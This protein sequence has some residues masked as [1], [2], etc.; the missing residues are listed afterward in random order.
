MLEGINYLD[1]SYQRVLDNLW[2]YLQ[3]GHPI[4]KEKG[5]LFETAFMYI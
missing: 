4:K 2:R 5:N 3:E 1:N